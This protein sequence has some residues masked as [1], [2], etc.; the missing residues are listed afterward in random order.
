MGAA[1]VLVGMETSGYHLAQ[2]NVGRTVAP[3][4]S[5]EMAGFRDG[6]AVINGLADR[7]PGFVWRLVGEAADD[8]TD[9]R[10]PGTDLIM[11][12]SVWESRQALWDFVYRSAH[13]DYLRRRRDWFQKLGTP[14]QVLWWLPAGTLPDIA[15]AKR[16]LEL[17]TAGGPGP[18][19]FTFR[20]FHEAPAPGPDAGQAEPVNA[21]R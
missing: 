11:N 13:L 21:G 20:E 8:A 2:F 12:L 17:L 18:D 14:I 19:A 9:L 7:T 16:R 5:G 15:E 1:G 6:L 10:L 3:M 4:D